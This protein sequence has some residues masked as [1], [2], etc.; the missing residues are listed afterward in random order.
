MRQHIQGFG[1]MSRQQLADQSPTTRIG[2]FFSPPTPCLHRHPPSFTPSRVSGCRPE[3]SLLIKV[4]VFM[5]CAVFAEGSPASQEVAF[6]KCLRGLD[7]AR[8]GET[9]S[10]CQLKIGGHSLSWP[11]CSLKNPRRRKE[12]S[13]GRD[14][15]RALDGL[16]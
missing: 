2:V 6:M 9:G 16:A 11:S 12:K 13:L 4:S 10:C 15:W 7:T 3:C 5:V 1:H 14:G 8:V